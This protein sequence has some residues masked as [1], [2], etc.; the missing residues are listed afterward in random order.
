[1]DRSLA[2]LRANQERSSWSH[3]LEVICIDSDLRYHADQAWN[4]YWRGAFTTRL[5]VTMNSG[6]MGPW[7]TVLGFIPLPWEPS[8]TAACGY[9]CILAS[10]NYWKLI[11]KSHSMATPPALSILLWVLPHWLYTL[12]GWTKSCSNVAIYCF[13]E[14]TSWL[15]AL[16][17]SVWPT[18]VMRPKLPL[19]GVMVHRPQ[20]L[21]HIPAPVHP[22]QY[23][24]RRWW[25]ALWSTSVGVSW[26]AQ[27][28][29]LPQ[30]LSRWS[31]GYIWT[32]PCTSLFFRHL[33]WF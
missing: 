17:T 12:R 23:H 26:L 25:I 3:F 15:V 29:F 18:G 10:H 9:F 7:L 11:S 22:P 16:R 27:P 13:K 30:T 5:D 19:L 6:L 32:Q 31:E 14:A 1:M 8:L 2:S 28:S 4:I 24:R 21:S 20:L 33:R